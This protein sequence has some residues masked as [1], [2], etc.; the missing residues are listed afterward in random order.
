MSLV[1]YGVIGSEAIDSSSEMLS[2]KGCDIST[3]AQSGVLNYEHVGNE[4]GSFNSIIGKCIKA[5]KI[6]SSSDCEDSNE[7]KCWAATGVPFIYGVF[8]LF[9][10]AGHPNAVAAAA[11]MRDQAAHGEDQILRLSIEGNTLESK[12]GVLV[13]TIAKNVALTKAP[14]NKTA[15]T[16][17][18]GDPQK[19]MSED[20]DLSD[21]LATKKG[22]DL[23]IRLSS[24]PFIYAPYE[25][26][27]DAID[28]F[29][30]NAKRVIELA[31]AMTAGG[32]N[33]APSSLTGGS[34]L[35]REDLGGD[36]RKRL[37]A[38]CKAALRDHNPMVH[39]PFRRFLKSLLPEVSDEFLDRFQEVADDLD[40]KA[41]LNYLRKDEGD[42]S[43]EKM[44]NAAKDDAYVRRD[45]ARHPK[46]PPE[47]MPQLAQDKDEGVRRYLALHP[48]LPPAAMSQ[49]AQDSSEYVRRNLAQHPK[50]PPE[51]MPQLAHDE[52]KYVRQNLA[53]HPQLS[54]EAMS[55]LA[56]DEDKY[57]RQ[58][59][60]GHPQLPPELM[61][62]L[63]QDKDEGVR[64]NLGRHPQ[65]PPA[66]MSQLAQDKD[67]YVRQNLAKHPQLPPEL[68]PRLAQDKD[69]GVRRN[70]ARHPKLPPAAMSQLAQDSDEGVRRYLALHPQLPPE[71][72]SRLAQDS[73]EY[74][75][76]NLA[77]HPQLPPE[78]MPQ[79]TQDKDEGVRQYLARHPQLSPEAMS[80]LAHDEDKYVRQNLAE[81][82]NLSP[83]AMSRL[84]QDENED[85]RQWVFEWHNPDQ[86]TKEH[87][88][89][90][91][92]TTKLRKIRDHILAQGK[93][94]MSPKD[95]PPGDWSVGRVSSG[96]IS[97]Q[98]IQEHIDRMSAT[99][100]T[101]SHGTW[102]GAQ[103]HS[104]ESSKVFQVGLSTDTIQ[105]LKAAGV[106][107]SFR[108]IYDENVTDAH[109]HGPSGI[110]W[111]RWTGD[112]KGVHIDE[113]QSDIGRQFGKYKEASSDKQ[114]LVPDEHRQKIKAIVFSDRHPNEVLHEAFQQHLRDRGWIDTPVHTW[115][116]E[117]KAPLSSLDANK[118]IPG[119]MQV[120][121]R[122]IPKKMG[123][124]EGR[125]GSLPTQKNK[126]LKDSTTVGDAVRKAEEQVVG[127]NWPDVFVNVSASEII[128]NAS[129]RYG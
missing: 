94:E 115:T 27:L 123:W 2:V 103:R 110:G 75:R 33:V 21:I 36:Q 91:Y 42:L 95:L 18:V 41:K 93:T 32:D 122:D 128:R 117:T 3:L 54:P 5:K 112:Q 62:R 66:A 80:R 30:V 65:L 73:S 81:H 14:C 22:G 106:Y 44:L 8:R 48:Q 68:M 104:G 39:G 23:N 129:I 37:I 64:R 79:L 99:R 10:G 15:I 108:K 98:K 69:E 24:V 1:I 116:P 89:V 31:K 87:V 43:V 17:I 51:L 71:L 76:R 105:K 111:V 97:A 101:I 57:V 78:L 4:D 77:Q 20:G 85:V 13:S 102:A 61:S 29:V 9:D 38:V 6:Y 16:G 40:V 125:Y 90:K 126:K 114:P 49:L 11:I 119:H 55:R 46:L 100:F 7:E 88:N 70:L 52:D 34:A 56:H 26:P 124:E 60:G 72:M 121:Y 127:V 35:M 74:V 12:D 113:V 50:L 84:A 82:P 45:L 86:L 25:E 28:A 83:E 19:E 63:A 92:N 47:L 58:N 118:P 53:G 120:T 59:L 107:G 109:P 96:N 67:E